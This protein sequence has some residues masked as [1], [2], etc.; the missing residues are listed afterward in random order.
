MFCLIGKFFY[1]YFN[2]ERDSLEL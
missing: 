1:Y 2:L